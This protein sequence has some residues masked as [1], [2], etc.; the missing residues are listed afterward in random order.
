MFPSGLKSKAIRC[1]SGDQRAVPAARSRLRKQFPG[2]GAVRIADPDAMDSAAAGF[3]GNPLAVGR[4][5]WS[6][7]TAC[8]GNEPSW[9]AAATPGAD[10]GRR[11][12][13]ESNPPL[14]RQPVT[15]PGDGWAE[16]SP[17]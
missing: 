13:L 15:A 2:V 10:S 6:R 17:P 1:P 8:G 12:M 7:I 14:V 4:V 5:L 16:A 9:G 3:K 11:H